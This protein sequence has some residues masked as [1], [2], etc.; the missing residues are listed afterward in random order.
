[1]TFLLDLSSIG[2]VLF[3]L[4]FIASI[5]LIFKT[6]NKIIVLAPIVIV[7]LF[8]LGAIHF[9]TEEISDSL[10]LFCLNKGFPDSK[11]INSFKGYCLN[12]ENDYLIEQETRLV[13][14]QWLL[15]KPSSLSIETDKEGK[16]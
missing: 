13:N 4:T 14:D 6:N 12:E 8:W 10:E 16:Q 9:G 11:V 7:G 15:V 2:F 3:I 1:M 5:F